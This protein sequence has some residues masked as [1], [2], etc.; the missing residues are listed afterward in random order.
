MSDEEN[1]W[2]AWQKV[3]LAKLGDLDKNQYGLRDQMQDINDILVETVGRSGKN[4]RL[5]MLTEKVEHQEEQLKA[6]EKQVS[7]EANASRAALLGG[8][9]LGGGG[10]AAVIEIIRALV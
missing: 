4:G 2:L 9:A 6:L 8:G 3:V 10:L 5:G 1:S 7:S